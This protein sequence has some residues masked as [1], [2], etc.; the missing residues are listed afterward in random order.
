VIV[1]CSEQK[2]RKS[3]AMKKFFFALFLYKKQRKKI[4]RFHGFARFRNFTDHHRASPSH[5]YSIRSGPEKPQHRYVISGSHHTRRIRPL[6]PR[7][8]SE[9]VQI[10]G[11][12]RPKATRPSV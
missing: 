4:F 10:A 11:P 9:T 1:D 8:N 12:H 3:G 6:L 7:P 2:K 5:T